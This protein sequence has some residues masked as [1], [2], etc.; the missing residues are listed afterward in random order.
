MDILNLLLSLK[1]KKL[2]EDQ[3]LL[4]LDNHINKI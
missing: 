4:E 3:V 2:I 1:Q